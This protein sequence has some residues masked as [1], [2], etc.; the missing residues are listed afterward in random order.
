M[1]T[2]YQLYL[3]LL[4]WVA[5]ERLGEL[6]LSRRNAEWALRRHGT[7]VGQRHYRVMVALHAGL[8]VS[9]AL[10]PVAFHRTFPGALGWAWLG[11]ALLAQA[12]RYWAVITLGRRW[13]TR[14]IVLPDAEP[15]TGGP[16]RF[17]RHPNYLAVALE[18]AALPLVFGSYWTA[19]AFSLANAAVLSVRIRVEERALGPR[20]QAAFA[21][22]GPFLRRGT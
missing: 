9:C 3:G 20:W 10:E 12:L 18:V 13:N 11:L 2:P 17:L 16:Y 6:A 4:S 8:L 19:L 5:V 1:V 15:V 22:R 14:V 7:E 21:G